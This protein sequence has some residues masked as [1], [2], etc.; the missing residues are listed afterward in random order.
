MLIKLVNWF[1]RRNGNVLRIIFERISPSLWQTRNEWIKL[2][3]LI[4]ILFRSFLIPNP[5]HRYCRPPV[6]IVARILDNAESYIT[7]EAAKELRNKLSA[8]GTQQDYDYDEILKRIIMSVQPPSDDS[9]EQIVF[10]KKYF[11]Y[12]PNDLDSEDETDEDSTQ[13][14][15]KS[16][17]DLISVEHENEGDN[18]RRVNSRKFKR[19][20]TGNSRQKRQ[21][22]YYYPLPL[23]H[24]SPYPNVNFYV[25]NDFPEYPAASSL[26]KRISSESYNNPNP[27]TPQNNPGNFHAPHNFYLPA[28]KPGVKWVGRISNP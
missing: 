26:Q 4:F 11:D 5:I 7:K 19:D 17:G 1:L 23:V 20:L 24:Y 14:L 18:V 9:P 10:E 16:Y 6:W 8:H 28:L 22:I 21:S 27:W 15:V 3:K 13:E 2:N 25:P 12:L